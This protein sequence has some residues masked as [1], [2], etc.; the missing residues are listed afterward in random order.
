MGEGVRYRELFHPSEVEFSKYS[1]EASDPAML[2]GLF[3]TY[4]GECKRLLDLGLPLP[5]YDMALRCSHSF[6]LLDARR[7]ISVTERQGYIGRVRALAHEC[8][9]GYLAQRER[10]GFP[11][12]QKGA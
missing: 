2:F 3:A 8:A 1:F 9:K 4:E 6:N 7:A 11:L 10:L 12:L 5:A